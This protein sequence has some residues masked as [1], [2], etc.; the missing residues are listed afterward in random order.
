MAAVLVAAELAYGDDLVVEPAL[1]GGPGGVLLGAKGVGV[2]VF[3]G[4]VPLVG[5]EL[6]GDALGDKTA[7]VLVALGDLGPERAC[8]TPWPIDAPMGTRDMTSTPAAMT[9]S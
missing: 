3:A 1:C 9:M 4:Q 2:E 6:G 5:D 8:R 7:P